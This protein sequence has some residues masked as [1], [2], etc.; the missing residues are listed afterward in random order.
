MAGRRR[1]GSDTHKYAKPCSFCGEHRL[2]FP[3]AGDPDIGI[4]KA[5]IANAAGAFARY[6]QDSGFKLIVDN[7]EPSAQPSE[8]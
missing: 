7:A 8:A 1:R 3:S 4:C 5:C 6:W 2:C